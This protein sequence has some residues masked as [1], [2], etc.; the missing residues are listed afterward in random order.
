MKKQFVGIILSVLCLFVLGLSTPAHATPLGIIWPANVGVDPTTLDSN[1]DTTLDWVVRGGGSFDMTKLVGGEWLGGGFGQLLD[2]RPLFAFDSA[3]DVDLRW[4]AAGGSP[5]DAT[6]W[7]NVNPAGDPSYAAVFFHLLDVGPSQTLEVYHKP[8]DIETLLAS[9]T[10]LADDTLLD[11]RF[12]F[13]GIDKV[14]VTIGGTTHAAL[15]YALTTSANAD[16]FA[17]ILGSDMR[18]DCIAIDAAGCSQ[19]HTAV[20]EPAT[21]ALAGLGLLGLGCFA[22][23]KKY[24]R[25]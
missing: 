24:R 2:T 14:A 10:G 16:A 4:K 13:D 8:L 15:T 5:F 9:Y 22:L 3:F 25:A 12:A 19:N 7:V 6:F 18:L 11:M 21:F 23:R 20:P 1:S 17:T